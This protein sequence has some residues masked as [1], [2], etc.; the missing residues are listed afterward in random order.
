MRIYQDMEFPSSDLE[1]MDRI[2]DT[3][4][5]STSRTHPNLRIDSITSWLWTIQ[6]RGSHCKLTLRQISTSG[7]YGKQPP[8]LKDPEPPIATGTGEILQQVIALNQ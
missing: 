7:E 5:L 6:T 4:F 1:N 8:P 2:Q 3:F